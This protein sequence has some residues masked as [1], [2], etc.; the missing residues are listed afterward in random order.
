MAKRGVIVAYWAGK[1]CRFDPFL[2]LEPLPL[3]KVLTIALT[4]ITNQITGSF[5]VL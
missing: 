3:G 1:K 4:K 5:G 2:A